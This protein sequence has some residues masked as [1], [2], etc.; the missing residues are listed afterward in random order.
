MNIRRARVVAIAALLFG[1]LV[2]RRAS[3]QVAEPLELGLGYQ[4]LHSSFDGAGE[5]FPIGAYVDVGHMLKS[6]NNKAWGWMGQF[7]AGFR[8]GSGFSEQ[9]YTVLGG[10]RV[11]STRPMKWTP[12]GHGLIGFG[13]LN[14]SCV[15]FCAGAEHG[16]AFQAGIAVSTRVN[17]KVSANIGFRATKLKVQGGGLFNAAV[18]AGV[19]M[20]LSRR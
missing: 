5:S 14:A 9:L 13:S 11:A 1:L 16:V 6:D 18:S 19:R 15:D 17:E 12:S 10:I 2:S 3:A 20:N 4:F 8:N 7:E